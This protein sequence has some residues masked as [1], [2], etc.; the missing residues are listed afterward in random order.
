MRVGQRLFLAV[1][2]AIVGL[3]AVAA[4]AYWGRINRS[5]PQWL[6]VVAVV[7]ALLSL[8]V[9]WQNTRYVARRIERLAGPKDIASAGAGSPLAVVRNAAL[10]RAGSSP[11]EIDSIERV[12]DRL[13][14]AVAVA[15]SERRE[16]EA[17]VSGR[18]QEYASLLAE[19]TT[20]VARQLDEVRLPI[21]ILLENHFGELNENQEE[22]LAGARAAAEAAGVELA[23]LREIADL[24]RGALNFRRD[25]VRCGDLLRA[26]KP[27]LEADGERADVKVTFDVMPGLPP[28]A[29]DRVRLQEALDL[30]LRLLVRH[31]LPGG[32][33][34]IG[35]RHDKKEITIEVAHGPVPMLDA[36]VALAQRIILAHGGRI[37]EQDG[38]MRIFLPAAGL[39]PAVIS[40]S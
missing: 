13:S 34:T 40:E 36:N 35:A 11:D 39:M 1:I 14:G 24:D 31:A 33:M 2:P 21:H 32:E 20:A 22:M 37:E 17:A 4:L 27:Q 6:V 12:V 23:R 15:E 38:R 9:A 19:A 3:F 30:L 28:V 18:V 8:A 26:L 16:R 7:A 10:P 29:G 25:R 5:A